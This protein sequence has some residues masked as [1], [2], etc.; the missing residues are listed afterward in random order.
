M[1]TVEAGGW[2]GAFSPVH[3]DVRIEQ[4]R[5]P[6]MTRE[7]SLSLAT[8]HPSLAIDHP[9]SGNI[10]LLMKGSRGPDPG[11]MDLKGIPMGNRKKRWRAGWKFNP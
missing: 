2:G 11:E 3:P 7:R 5:I 9:H 10:I 1:V 6:A 4:T 8:Y